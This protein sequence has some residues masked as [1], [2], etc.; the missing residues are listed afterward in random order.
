[1][2]EPSKPSTSL[3]PRWFIRSFWW[4]SAVSA[5]RPTANARAGDP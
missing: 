1:M 3:P 5:I 2:S 4:G